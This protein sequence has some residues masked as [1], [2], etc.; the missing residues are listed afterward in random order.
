MA[1]AERVLLESENHEY[2]TV[3]HLSMNLLSTLLSSYSSLEGS[4]ILRRCT[5]LLERSCPITTWAPLVRA[6]AGH[7]SVTYDSLSPPRP[8]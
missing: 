8:A 4:F 1:L 7:L 5:F 6:F 3:L 2:E